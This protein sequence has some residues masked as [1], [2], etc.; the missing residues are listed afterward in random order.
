MRR[1]TVGWKYHK[2]SNKGTGHRIKTTGAPLLEGIP[3]FQGLF[4]RMNIAP[5]LARIWPEMKENGPGTPQA[6]EEKPR[7]AFIGEFMVTMLLDWNTRLNGN[8]L[9]SWTRRQLYVTNIS[10]WPISAI[11]LSTAYL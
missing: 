2:F 5:F 3:G 11:N 9:A 4:Y 1:G 7:G 8:S 6:E 10:V